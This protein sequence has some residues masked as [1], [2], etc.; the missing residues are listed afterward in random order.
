MGGKASPG[1]RRA[2]LRLWALWSSGSILV[3][4]SIPVSHPQVSG[5]LHR[6][7][8]APTHSQE[9]CLPPTPVVP[10]RASIFTFSGLT[11]LPSCFLSVTE[12]L[13]DLHPSNQSIPPQLPRRGPPAGLVQSSSGTMKDPKPSSFLPQSLAGS[14]PPLQGQRGRGG[15]GVSARVS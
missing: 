11:S 2:A 10:P 7:I 1:G 3:P 14:F 4:H 9:F 15:A 12:R 5:S 8:S 6:S 13:P